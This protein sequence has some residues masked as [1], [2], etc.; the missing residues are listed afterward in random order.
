MR[1][2]TSKIV[3]L[4]SAALLASTMLAAGQGAPE[5]KDKE[6]AQPPGATQSQPKAPGAQQQREERGGQAQ[7]SKPSTSGQAAPTEEKGRTQEKAQEKREPGQ[8]RT[9]GQNQPQNQREQT[10]PQQGQ[11]QQPNRTEGRGEQAGKAAGGTGSVTL[12]SEQRT[13]VRQTVIDARGAPKVSRV[14]FAIS[15][16]TVIP[17][18][19]HVVAVPEVLI[20]IHPEWRG[21][22]YFV[23]NDEVIIVEPG[24]LRII[25]IVPG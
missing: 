15:E 25:A 14:D 24:T 8:T 12:T 3:I 16:G 19:V 11:N 22:E 13:K 7:Q 9:Q 18:T 17:R 5:R 23:Y 20:E 2:V 4:S 6:G 10:R 1:Q 21:F